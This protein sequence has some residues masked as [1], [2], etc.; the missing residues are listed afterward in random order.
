MGAEKRRFVSSGFVISLLSISGFGRTP[1]LDRCR[2]CYRIPMMLALIRTIAGL[3]PAGVGV[4]VTVYVG[5]SG[6]NA[7]RVKKDAASLRGD[8]RV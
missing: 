5:A 4:W 3:I 2:H 1:R 6:K 7:S 8:R